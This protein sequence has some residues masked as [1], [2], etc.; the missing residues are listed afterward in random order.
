MSEVMRVFAGVTVDVENQRQMST[1]T[2]KKDRLSISIEAYRSLF[3]TNNQLI[4]E[5]KGTSF[6]PLQLER[7]KSISNWQIVVF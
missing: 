2:K 3:D 7:K 5:L 4:A 1:L 6:P